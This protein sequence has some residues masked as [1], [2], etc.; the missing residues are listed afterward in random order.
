MDNSNMN[1]SDMDN[2]DMENAKNIRTVKILSGVVCVLVVLVVVG[3]FFVFK[4][5]QDK[6]EVAPQTTVTPEPSKVEE[7]PIPTVAP[8]EL[9]TATPVPTATPTPAP[10]ATPV[11]TPTNAPVT[12][13]G[14]P[15]SVWLYEG[16]YVDTSADFSLPDSEM[17]PYYFVDIANVTDT[18]FDFTIYIVNPA[19]GTEEVTFDTNTAVFIG[20][21]DE[22]IFV[23]DTH[24]LNFSFPDDFESLPVVVA[25]EIEGFDEIE[26]RLFANSNVPGH[27]FG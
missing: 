24:I 5:R 10:T 23:G 20:D 13:E 15:A 1:N 11:P 26:G 16:Y 12:P 4:D 22:A 19:N 8:E 27:E 9:P 3:W 6:Q 25:M 7:T 17:E 14:V 18:T 21:G 2:K